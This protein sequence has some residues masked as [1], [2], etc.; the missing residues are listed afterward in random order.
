MIFLLLAVTA[1]TYLLGDAY[2]RYIAPEQK[3][4]EKTLSKFIKI[5]S[6]VFRRVKQNSFGTA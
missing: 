1:G 2:K 6:H 3:K 5:N 4:N